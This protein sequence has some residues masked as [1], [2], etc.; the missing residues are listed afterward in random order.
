MREL[1]TNAATLFKK[2]AAAIADVVNF[3]MFDSVFYEKK[4]AMVLGISQ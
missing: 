3:T 4:L 1:G 2:N